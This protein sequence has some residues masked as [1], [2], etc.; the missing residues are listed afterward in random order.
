LVKFANQLKKERPKLTIHTIF[1]VFFQTVYL[2][3][4]PFLRS[5]YVVAIATS[6]Q[7]KNC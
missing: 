3:F 4:L 1:N 6:K 2:D 7:K 5:F